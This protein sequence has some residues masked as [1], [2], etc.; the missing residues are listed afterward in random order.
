MAL[1]PMLL[2]I[3]AGFSQDPGGIH[4]VPGGLNSWAGPGLGL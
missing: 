1:S 3:Q 4:E 2:G